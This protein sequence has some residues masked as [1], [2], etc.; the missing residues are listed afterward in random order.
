[1]PT[2][3]EKHLDQE[4][5]LTSISNG[6]GSLLDKLT[7]AIFE[8][9]QFIIKNI[10]LLSV[11]LIIG[12]AVG[13][14]MDLSG[15]IYKNQIIVAPNFGSTDYL[16]AKIKLLDSKIT[17]GDTVFLKAI[18]VQHPK[19]I[20]K[21]EI[22]PIVDIYSFVST[23]SGDK[24]FELLKLMAEDGDIN[25]IVTENITSKNY[26]F[27][28]ISFETNSLTNSSQT[29]QPIMEYLNDS[30]FYKKMQTASIENAKRKII[31]DG[32][33]IMQ[34]D[35]ILNGMAKNV[36]T[37]RTDK[38]VYYNENTELNEVLKTK[39]LLIRDQNSQKINLIGTDKV[40]KDRSFTTNIKSSTGLTGKKKFIVP[41]LFIA[42]YLMFA[43][44]RNLYKK[45]AAE[46]IS[47]S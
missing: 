34:I 7:Y 25:K 47:K 24:N 11:L 29:V 28:T 14:Y 19:N 36:E 1:M 46:K 43:I 18:G 26:S 41:A 45:H 13:V 22:N 30:P 2:N 12:A 33:M 8:S 5:N 42:I 39:D 15:K 40:I 27:H 10:I 23:T 32:A 35:A 20:K 38:L 6:V 17:E 4:I 37:G 31:E 3:Q 16:Y 21:I 9:I 44:M